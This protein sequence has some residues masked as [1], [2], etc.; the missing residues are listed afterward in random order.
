MLIPIKWL[1]EFVEIKLTPEELGEKLVSCGFE[2]EDIKPVKK[3]IQNVYACKITNIT[4]HPELPSKMVYSFSRDQERT[5][6][7][8]ADANL[9]GTGDI[10]A[11]AFEKASCTEYVLDFVPSNIGG[12]LNCAKI[13]TG[14]DLRLDDAECPTQSAND[15]LKFINVVTGTDV[16][17]LLPNDDIVLDVGITANRTDANSIYGIAREVA[18]VTGCKLK[19]LDLSYREFAI[20]ASKTLTL[21]NEAPDL[22][23]RYMAKIVANVKIERS[24]KL[25][26][27]RLNAVGLKAINN[28][29]DVTNYVLYEIGQP[30]HAFDLAA[31]GGNIVVRRATDGEKITALDDSEYDLGESNLVI[32]NA[33]EPM[34]IAGVMGGK[35]HSITDD[36]VDIVFESAGFARDNVR[37]T[38]KALGL[39]S[40]SS[41]RFEKGI[42]VYSQQIGLERA[43]AL[44]FKYGWGKPAKGCLDSRE[45]PSE[46][47]KIVFENSEITNILGLEIP[48]ATIKKL[49]NSLEFEVS[50]VGRKTIV[51]V[52]Y[53]R[54][55]V[56]CVNDIAEELIRLYGYDKIPDAP[57]ETWRLAK[58]CRSDALK[59]T[60]KLKNVLIAKGCF[61]ILTYSF[62][63]PKVFD[64]LNIAEG[65]VLRNAIR[66]QNPLGEDLSIM[67]TVLVDGALKAISN[68]TQ[69][70]NKEC[71]FFEIAK[72]YAPGVSDKDYPI[73]KSR[74]AIVSTSDD[75]YTFK[76]IIE[77][78]FSV[79]NVKARFVRDATA[80]MHPGRS[81]AIF[82]TVSGCKIGSFGEVSADV[83]NKYEIDRRVYFAQLDLEHILSCISP[84]IFD[85][86]SKY[87]A[88]ERDFAVVVKNDIE[89]GTIIDV[90]KDTGGEFLTNVEVF[91]VYTGSQIESGYKS[92]AF[93]MTFRSI[94]RTLTDEEVNIAMS[95]ILDGLTRIGAVLR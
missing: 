18:A 80:Y 92:V 45:M 15:V 90:V 63:S 28:I 39:R 53:H 87:P 93:N 19:P 74:L 33:N 68:N 40:D 27:E 95:A 5:F 91:D 77:E 72:T 78:V 75:F 7:L 67:R 1:S 16:K 42:D 81:S 51:T 79:F 2:V 83:T 36:T 13:C 66:I 70:G 56:T 49:L 38:S 64:K 84:I 11:V 59:A 46:R 61:E 47:V 3:C 24:P 31:T 52:P 54:E 34:A 85:P 71:R 62:T 89:V 29:V 37:N 6:T 48:K 26:I 88:S 4:S 17:D 10:V 14:K 73:E 35:F 23:K 57:I 60:D 32:A 30:M 44:M 21:S 76:A 50:V 94:T 20:D 82:D 12:I 8:V 86:I 43:T 58:G 25:I 55:D 69:R 22:C 9:C 41:A 65:D